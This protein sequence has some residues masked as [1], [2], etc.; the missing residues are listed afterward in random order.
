MNTQE[1]KNEIK[2][3]VTE[4]LTDSLSYMIEKI[5]KVLDCGAID[6]ESWCED[7]APMV[8]PKTIA[9]ALLHSEAWQYEG[10]GTSYEKQVKKDIRNIH[11][12]V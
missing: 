10:K 2:S 8:L 5:D 11:Y 9:A 12:F 3:L 1:K 7:N 6:A 4:M